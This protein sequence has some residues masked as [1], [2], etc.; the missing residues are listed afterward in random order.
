MVIEVE[1]AF[2]LGIES[3]YKHLCISYANNEPVMYVE[4]NWFYET[5]V[6]I[7][8][9]EAFCFFGLI[10]KSIPADA[11]IVS[12]IFNVLKHF[13]DV[14]IFNNC[15]SQRLELWEENCVKVALL[16]EFGLSLFHLIRDFDAKYNMVKKFH[17]ALIRPKKESKD[18]P[19]LELWIEFSILFSF[20][21][22]SNVVGLDITNVRLRQNI[23]YKL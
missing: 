19:F 16:R 21:L 17:R 3:N 14:P 1:N 18:H 8:V 13:F 23:V 4:L 20:F 22:T 10:R 9:D 6:L 2:V 11:S 15:N 7:R 5:K 12:E